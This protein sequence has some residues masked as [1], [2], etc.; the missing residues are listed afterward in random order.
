MSGIL[1][2]DLTVALDEVDRVAARIITICRD[3]SAVAGDDR[4]ASRLLAEA[5]ER[6]AAL[7]RYNEARM[8]HG[9]IPEVDDPELS[10]LQ[11]IWLK[12]RS[13]LAKPTPEEF[14]AAA[15][16]E[17]DQVLQQT[18]AAAQ[19]LHPADD[20]ASAMEHLIAARRSG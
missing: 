4:S 15:L 2:D 18:V 13:V 10:H 3:L 1:K 7:A 12:L 19:A 16:K 5:G 6:E 14:L 8:A 17:L 9:Q 11:A 20:I